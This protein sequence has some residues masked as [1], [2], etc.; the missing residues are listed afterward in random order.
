MRDRKVDI[1]IFYLADN[2]I[3]VTGAN[4]SMVQ[5]HPQMQHFQQTDTTMTRIDMSKKDMSLKLK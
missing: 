5:A 4:A 3:S 1:S 2:K